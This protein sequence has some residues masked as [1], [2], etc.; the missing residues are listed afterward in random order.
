MEE[1]TSEDQHLITVVKNI[2]GDDSF[3]A[4]QYSGRKS[5]LFLVSPHDI[6]DDPDFNGVFQFLK[7]A[8]ASQIAAGV[9]MVCHKNVAYYIREF[10]QLVVFFAKNRGSS[11][12][13][14]TISTHPICANHSALLVCTP[15]FLSMYSQIFH[16]SG[17]FHNFSEDTDTIFDSLRW[18]GSNHNFPPEA[19]RSRPDNVTEDCLQNR[20]AAWYAALHSLAALN[21]NPN[22]GGTLNNDRC[23]LLLDPL[24]INVDKFP[25]LDAFGLGFFVGIL[26]SNFIPH[27]NFQ[28]LMNHR[29][30]QSFKS[31]KLIPIE[32]NGS[33]SIYCIPE[34]L[35]GF[36]FNLTDFHDHMIVCCNNFFSKL[37]EIEIIE[38]HLFELNGIVLFF[39]RLHFLTSPQLCP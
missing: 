2:V 37:S 9:L 5:F 32:I 31:R 36:K 21:E 20:L 38:K 28:E 13:I 19:V 18:R 27:D 26:N 10:V 4:G 39:Y 30:A 22:K 8:D 11:P 12:M 23:H 3:S 29:F 14:V 35:H 24:F 25:R 7:Y 33:I 34:Y 15:Q 17:M 6:G 1:S 16:R